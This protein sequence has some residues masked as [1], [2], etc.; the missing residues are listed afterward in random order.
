MK[1]ASAGMIT[2]LNTTTEYNMADLWTVTL[3]S[4]AVYRWTNYNIDLV[5]G[6]NTFLAKPGAPIIN[7]G[8]TRCA[9]GLEVDTLAVELG[10]GDGGFQIGGIHLP[11]A[12]DNGLFDGALVLLQRVF[13]PQPG[14]TTPGAITLFSGY[15]AGVVPSSTSVKLTAKSDLAKLLRQMPRNLYQPGCS[16][17]LYDAG[18]G[19]NKASFT[20]SGTV[21]AS[22]AP[23]PLAVA[24]NLSAADGYFELGVMT[25][26]SGAC[27]GAQRGVRGFT[28]SGGIVALAV[29]LPAT[30]AAGDTFTIF[31]GCAKTQAVC[32]TKFVNIVHFR[33]FP[34]IPKPEN[35]R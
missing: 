18:C 12:A 8:A 27:T 11:V 15:V 32:D 1:T 23:T 28:A 6:G 2:L 21:S 35:A 17:I 33:G 3:F 7:R 26:T 19:L 22:P 25:F 29:S 24:T 34:Y 10:V 16:H 5:L 4:G 31:P 14:N 20:V 9:V 13:M 30:P